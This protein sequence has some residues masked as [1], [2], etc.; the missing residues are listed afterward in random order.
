MTDPIHQWTALQ[1]AAH[2]TARHISATEIAQAICARV[3]RLEPR[4]NAFADFDPEVP[5]QAARDVDARLAAGEPLPLAGVL[6]T[7]KDNLWLSGRPATFGSRV[8]A[9]FVAPRDSWCVA[10]L[11]ALGAVPLGVTNCSEFACKGIT[12]TPLHGATRNPWDPERTPGGSSGGAVAA[13]AAG[14][15]PLALVT[16]AGGSTRRPAAHTGLVGMKPTLGRVPNAWG[17]D[18]P[19]HLLSVIGQVGRTVEDVAFLLDA[20]TAWD[21]ADPLSSPAFA[22]P[23]AMAGLRRPPGAPRLAWSPHL[24]CGLPV[25]ADVLATLE[26]AVERLRGAG[27][28]IEQADPAWPEGAREY[29]MIALQQAGLAQRFGGIWRT[30]PERLDPDIGA[31]IELGFSI[32]GTRITELL[33]LR[34]AF[35]ASF[36]Q[37]FDRYDALLCPTSPVEAWPLGSLGPAEIG[38]LPAGPRGH[39]A[40]TPLFNYGSVPALSLPCGTGRNGLPV[41]LQIAGPR[42]S[43][44]FVLRLA[45]HAEQVLGTGAHSPLMAG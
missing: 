30:H 40:F 25:D 5:L 4:L 12:D 24:G 32:T 39:A 44:A 34:E 36:T 18:D 37:F 19:N 13:V 6:F 11:R 31:Q 35:H 22:V 42:F 16:D 26:A 21:P 29:P 10:R 17:F 9:D 1:T 14:L 43:D 38:G 15:G 23:D 2:V 8:F 41:G 27:W 3:A 45:W 28:Q 7:V 33:K 20:L